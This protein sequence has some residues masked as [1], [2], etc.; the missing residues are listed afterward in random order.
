M[1]NRNS[2]TRC[3]EVQE[4][5][6]KVK[7]DVQGATQ[8][9]KENINTIQ[10]QLDILEKRLNAFLKDNADEHSELTKTLKDL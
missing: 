1:G 2:N 4:D 5:L 6:N 7:G 10:I 8:Q 9:V 3:D